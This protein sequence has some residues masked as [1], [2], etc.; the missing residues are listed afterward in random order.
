MAAILTRR[1]FLTY[2]SA[3]A[4]GLTLG[5]A[6]RRWLARADER[7][8]EFAA[9]AGIETLATSVCR[10]CPAA[11]GLRV[12]TIDGTPVKV[13]GNPNC[14][15]ARGR[16][17][18]KGQASLEAYFD[19]DRL[20]GPA[21]RVGRRGDN[22]WAPISWSDGVALLASHLKTASAPG[23]IVALSA[24]ERGPIADAWSQFWERRGARVGWTL[25]STAE[26]LAPA[27]TALTGSIAD[28]VFDLEHAT[29]VLSFGA[30]IVE[31]WLSPV[32]SQRSYGRFRRGPSR[33]RGRLIHIDQR[34]SLTARKADE[35]LPIAAERQSTLAYGVA[36]VLLREDRVDR[37]QLAA[38][39]SNAADF[40]SAVISHYTPDAVALAT[41]VPVVTLLRLARDLV[42]SPQ[43]LVVVDANAPRTL[44]EA[45]FALNA[46][47]GAL[48]RP[49]GVLAG[50]AARTA[51]RARR[52]ALSVLEGLSGDAHPTAVLALRDA[53]ALRSL[54]APVDV[55]RALARCEFVVSFS[56]YLDEAA[57]SADLLLPA[58][59]PLESWHASVPPESDGAER[60]ACARPAAP[61]RLDTRDVVATLRM[62]AEATGAADAASMPASS[63]EA[64][65]PEL[66]RIWKLR[67]GAPFATTFETNWL[68][69]LERGGWWVPPAG[70]REEFGRAVL[71]AGGWVD[72]F[73]AAGSLRRSIAGRGGLTFVPPPAGE[74][75][76]LAP[77]TS[78]VSL[79]DMR[80]APAGSST[81][82]LVAFTPATVNLAGG[83]NQPALFEL[84]GQPENAAWRVWAE[85]DQETARR[86]GIAPGAAIRISSSAGSIVALATVF[87]HI[88][89]NTIAVAYV[90]ALRRG[91][92][93]A[94]EV[95]ADVRTLWD[96]AAREPI[97]VRVAP[98]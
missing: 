86:L 23:A 33:P 92:R 64:I 15:I 44:V 13:D 70:T 8:A 49:G 28:P 45:V 55:T 6:G 57:L 73:V 41:G 76:R 56:P 53:S 62:T 25:P 26:R 89:P 80:P 17:C 31:D 78:T 52:D 37:R 65:E 81:L 72:P 71:D 88:P 19:P 84:L 93:W 2:G 83:P 96:G 12:R 63:E 1:D 9:R 20:V 24:H 11:C 98:V 4:T 35:W 34:R 43:P 38:L 5:E 85:L 79:D 18:A 91:G 21:K 7:A 74:L 67:R 87:E 51:Q 32:W 27:F 14:P 69:Q 39:A 95:D 3:V 59:T 90:P 50:S 29:H 36:S 54:D 60:I 75:D 61:A 10:E 47:I 42:A 77:P 94:R 22:Q 40:E 58:H 82:Q 48:D 30:P 46:L 97:S 66:D 16:I 68:R